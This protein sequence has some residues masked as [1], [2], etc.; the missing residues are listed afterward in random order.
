MHM[1]IYAFSEKNHTLHKYTV[2]DCLENEKL[3][4]SQDVYYT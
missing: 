3:S 2:S 4:S 1:D